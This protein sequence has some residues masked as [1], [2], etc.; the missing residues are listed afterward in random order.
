MKIYFNELR[1]NKMIA[2]LSACLIVFIDSIGMGLVFP[3][4]PALFA[5]SNNGLIIDSPSTNA[6]VLYG[7]AV[8]IYPFASLIGMPVLGKLSDI[9]GRKKLLL[10]GLL[11]LLGG[12]LL[13]AF[14]IFT[15]NL[16]FFFLSRFVS[17]FSAGTYSICGAVIVDLSNDA[18]NKVTGLKYL[19]LATIA[20]F[21]LG[22]ALS[23]FINDVNDSLINPFL[24]T[25]GLCGLNILLLLVIFPEP[26]PKC[27]DKKIVFFDEVLEAFKLV[28]KNNLRFLVLG[29]L[30]FN[31]GFEVFLQSQSL[32]LKESFS[33]STKQIG[34]FFAIMGGVFAFS[35]FILHPAVNKK[36]K[37]NQQICTSIFMMGGSLILYS[38]LIIKIIESNNIH[39][40]FSWV[41]SIFFYLITPF[42]TLN[43]TKILSDTV[44]NDSQGNL[45]GVL[46]QISSIATVFGG[47]IMGF[48]TSIEPNYNAVFGGGLILFGGLILRELLKL[49]SQNDL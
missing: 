47:V 25:S 7:F 4:L 8:A 5:I 13:S 6:N 36:Y 22:P 41:N 34:L 28:F 43:M 44:S 21:I 17:G 38:F 30:L 23:F 46:G 20:G 11:G 37:M 29:Y 2:L 19:T 12:Y 26:E 31:L 40:I 10:Y 27:F 48:I 35:M 33:Y 18:L 1:K 9:Y 32:Y 3:L 14:S 24:I 16:N 45:M 39:A 49:E 42:V 15:H